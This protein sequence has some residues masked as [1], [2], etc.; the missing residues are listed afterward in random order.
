[1]NTLGMH[2]TR[3]FND[4]LPLQ[5][6]ASAN[7]IMAYRDT[8]V[9]LLEFLVSQSGLQV[10][11]LPCD[12]LTDES[13]LAFLAFMEAERHIRPSTRNQRLAG[14]HSFCKFLQRKE[15]S[16][17][18][19][20]NAILGIAFKKTPMKS[21]AYMSM[22][23]VEVLLA[24]PDVGTV[25]GRRD[26][27]LLLLLYDTGARVQE[28]IDLKYSQMRLGGK[29]ATLVLHGKGNKDRLVPLQA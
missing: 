1:M 8:F 14:I 9:L 25:R 5:C 20:C 3:F 2:V 27:A 17:I 26:L 16:C 19:N 7:T 28:M 15:P 11:E 4:Y 6:G 23:E 24:Q 12:C 18:D 29:M 10:N 13:V 21:I 22:E